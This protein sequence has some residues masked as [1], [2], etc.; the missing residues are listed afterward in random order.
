VDISRDYAAWFTESSTMPIIGDV[1]VSGGRVLGGVVRAQVAS[2]AEWRLRAKA[3][4]ARVTKLM[5][6]QK[7]VQ[8]HL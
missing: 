6:V 4:Q 8:K 2:G 5:K 3:L 1:P 7:R